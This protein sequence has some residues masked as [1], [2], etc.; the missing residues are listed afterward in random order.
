MRIYLRD[1]PHLALTCFK[2]AKEVHTIIKDYNDL[3]NKETL[4]KIK[5]KIIQ[6]VPF[7]EI[8]LFGS[9]V[10]GNWTNESDYDIMVCNIIAE[11]HKEM[12]KNIDFGVE[13][14]L[15]FSPSKTE[16]SFYIKL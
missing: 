2:Q 6:A 16:N 9:R 1:N 12:I 4:T 7:A 11:C 10:N 15:F 8:L 5:D 13:V 3:A 14:D